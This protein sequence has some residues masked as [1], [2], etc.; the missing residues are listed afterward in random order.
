MGV[1]EIIGFEN[2][3]NFTIEMRG[4]RLLSRPM[5]RQDIAGVWFPKILPIRISHGKIGNFWHAQPQHNFIRREKSN[6]TPNNSRKVYVVRESD[7][8]SLGNYSVLQSTRPTNT[9][10]ACMQLALGHTNIAFTWCNCPR[11]VYAQMHHVVCITFWI[12]LNAQCT[13]ITRRR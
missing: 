8:K 2:Y 3:V 5:G 11:T 7:C 1:W 13:Q 10:P 9:T 4:G 12:F 6:A